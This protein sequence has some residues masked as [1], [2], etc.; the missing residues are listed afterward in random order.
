MSERLYVCM[1]VCEN[2][3]KGRRL[4][5][6]QVIIKKA[7]RRVQGKNEE[8][9]R[10]DRLGLNDVET[11]SVRREGEKGKGKDDCRRLGWAV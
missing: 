6:I 2:E 11:E 3:R 1:R 7:E 8:T 4:G 10:K 9:G 5:R